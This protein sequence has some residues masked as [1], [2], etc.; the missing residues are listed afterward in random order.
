MLTLWTLLL[1]AVVFLGG[2]FAPHD[3]AASVG[4]PWAP[5]GGGLFLGTDD[6]GR[7]VL[8]RVLAGG[9][10][11]TAVALVAA[12]T[13]AALGT[14]GGLAA[15]WAGGRIDRLLTGLADLL[16]AVP[17]L[18]QAMVLAVALPAPAAV[19]AGTVCG[20]A[21]LGLRVIRDLTR[22][23]RGSG[24]VE[25]AR[26]RGETALAILVREVL[27]SIAGAAAADLVMRF[28]LALQLAAAFGMLGIGPEP[29][30][31]DWGLMLRENLPGA[32]L[33]PM[34]LVAP[35]A[36]LAVVAVTAATLARMLGQARR[37][38]PAPVRHVEQVARPAGS[39]LVVA[40]LGVADS[41]E[42]PIIAGFALRADP[43]EVVAIV[44]PS[45]SGKTTAL[46]AVLDLLGE[47]LQRTGGA[48]CW[49]GRAVPTGRAGRRWRRAH[50]GIV[51]Q[52]PVASLDPLMTVGASLL[53][54]RRG[55][56]SVARDM[57]AELG[58]D[59]GR[60]WS[61][62]AH[63]LSGGQA[64]RVALARAL[65]TDPP[66]LVLDEPT[67][68]LDQGALGLVVDALER[69][70]GDGRSITL[71][72]SHDRGFVARVADRIIDLTP[73]GVDRA[74]CGPVPEAVAGPPPSADDVL[75]VAGL[76]LAYGPT[77]LL[78]VEELSLR[79]G[80]LVALTGPSGSGKS[81]LL[82]ALAGLHVPQ[83]GH[84]KLRGQPVTWPLE[85]RG[86]AEIRAIQ[87]VGQDPVGALN[88]AHRVG[89]IVA[90]PLRRTA[91]MT[92]AEANAHVPELLR[93]VGLDPAL[94]ARRPGELSG[95]QRQRVALARA[96]AAGPAVL[97]AD[98]I[99][100]ALDAASAAAILRLLADLRAGG[101]AVLLATH[102]QAVASRADRVLHVHDRTLVPRPLA[103][104]ETDDP[105][106]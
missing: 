88:P 5:P 30:A 61:R 45:G 48:V 52:D 54:G 51:D 21:P 97:L 85:R 42:K 70:R 76:R 36:V 12:V 1:L 23:A 40:G 74:V 91:G 87:F 64:Q 14:A 4:A 43:G 13:A 32:G 16:L 3:P 25:A 82:R 28:V 102:D 90:R 27:P 86:R 26:G 58:L 57:L 60:L 15:G 46:R 62:R 101:L 75:T 24:Y 17:F 104:T 78:D 106:R 41:R 34:A 22:H 71:L 66:L 50:V 11:L 47:G 2:V 49:N 65:L 81:T 29:P 20:G 33:N 37:P 44:G 59:A 79:R 55:L 39:G 99:T 95:G 10:G 98:E 6:A 92:R 35:A 96:L 53:D 69:R 89:T 31:P 67:S 72:I 105:A 8:S 93:G 68:G 38:R 84:L 80:E 56:E 73:P 100:S 94:T 18:L 83:Q 9:R 63:R 77:A 7:D 103:R 19:I